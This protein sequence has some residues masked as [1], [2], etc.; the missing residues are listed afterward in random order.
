MKSKTPYIV[1]SLDCSTAHISKRDNNLLKKNDDTDPVTAYKNK[2][3]YDIYIHEAAMDSVP[4]RYG[5]S[6]EF[7]KLLKIARKNNCQYLKLDRDGTEYED[8]PRFDW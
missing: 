4:L 3:G 8:L 2:Y 7:V 1:M 5:Y 6:K